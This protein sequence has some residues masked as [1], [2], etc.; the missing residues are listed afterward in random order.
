MR[1]VD[2]SNLEVLSLSHNQ[3]GGEIPAELANIPTLGTLSLYNNLFTGCIP[4]ELKRI[5]A[6]DLGS[7]DLP[8]CEEGMCS[9]GTAVENPNANRGL[10]SDCQ[11]LAAALDTLRGSVSLDWST[12][13][14]IEEWEGVVISDSPRRV[15]EL[16]LSV[17]SLDGT[18]PPELGN[19]T[20]LKILSLSGNALTGEIP[21]RLAKL[22]SLET[23][24]LDDNQ[25]SG[26]I[27]PDLVR[28]TNL[29]E[30]HL[31][32]NQFTGCIPDGLE[33]VEDNDLDTFDN[34][35]LCG[36]V[37]CS[38]GTAVDEPGSN[39]GLVADC[40]LLLELRDELAGSAFL[41][42]SP[43]IAVNSPGMVLR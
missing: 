9:A 3:L 24:S 42:W 10:T 40:E 14:S 30:L 28:L 12:E 22:S 20:K 11:A 43:H 37:D 39:E 36:E 29:K 16:D 26:Q 34:L 38:S 7:L 21:S 27:P 35:P 5:Q 32:G 13:I 2:L 15:I 18:I 4:K 1:W 23:L 31:S 19:I 33:D 17:K 6:N 8:F 25:L 41:N